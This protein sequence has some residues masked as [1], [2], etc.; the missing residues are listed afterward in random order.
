M[1]RQTRFTTL[2][3][4]LVT[5]SVLAVEPSM[6]ST[7]AVPEALKPPADQ[8]LAFELQATGVQIYECRASK[9]D[10]ARFE[11][12]FKAPQAVLFD[13]K[14]N[15]VGNHYGGPTWEGL[16]GSNVVGDVKAKDTSLSSGSIPWLLLSAKSTSGNGLFSRIKSI[17]RLNTSGG[18]AP[19]TAS[20]AQAGQEAK[21]PYTATYAFYVT[22]P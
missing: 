20:Q 7:K 21:V 15:R 1:R 19:A 17:Q 22:K 12:V 5:L 16:D 18:A 14:G 11:W 9:D 13:A 4:A 10:P 2:G 3:A 6:Q 8:V